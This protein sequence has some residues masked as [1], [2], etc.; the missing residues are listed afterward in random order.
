MSSWNE[1]D[2]LLF[3]EDSSAGDASDGLDN[4][5]LAVFEAK[6]STGVLKEIINNK[7]KRINY[8]KLV[9]A[10]DSF[11]VDNHVITFID[12]SGGDNLVAEAFL[13]R[14]SSV[15]QS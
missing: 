10:L 3:D 12:D 15:W 6:N 4:M 8:L 9:A 1:A 2:S 14:A 11:A 5:E 7:F 13:V